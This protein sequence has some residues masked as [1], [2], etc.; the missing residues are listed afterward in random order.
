MITEELKIII[1]LPKAPLDPYSAEPDLKVLTLL[2][3]E[4]GVGLIDNS[5]APFSPKI[6]VLKGGGSWADS[7]TSD[8]RTLLSTSVDNV[9][10]TMNLKLVESTHTLMAGRIVELNRFLQLA[11]KF[12]ATYW[13]TQPVYLEWRGRGAPGSQFALIY[14]IDYA[15][16]PDSYPDESEP[17]SADVVLT[18]EREPAWRPLPPGA[19]PKLWAFYARGELPGAGVNKFTYAD[20]SLVNGARH[21]K[22]ATIQNMHEWTGT[23]VGAYQVPLSKNYVDIAAADVPGD[24]P[25]LLAVSVDPASVNPD[26]C[27]IARSIKP[28]SG[29]D[30]T[31]ATQYVAY[32]FNAGDADG[33]DA[34][35]VKTLSANGLI[36][37]GSNTNRYYA[38]T[39]IIASG[40]AFILWG[41]GSAQPINN[42]ELLRGKFVVLA[43]AHTTTAAAQIYAQLTCLYGSITVELPETTVPFNAGTTRPLWTYV[44]LFDF[45]VIERAIVSEFGTGRLIGSTNYINIILNYRNALASP[46]TIL[47][48]DLQFLPYDEYL[49]YGVTTATNGTPQVLFDGTGY[50]PR[51]QVKE[52]A[53]G[54]DESAVGAPFGGYPVELRGQVPKLEPNTDQRIYFSFAQGSSRTAYLE[55]IAVNLNIIPRWYGQRDV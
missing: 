41:T 53:Y 55:N 36:S 19:N 51:G 9:T 20:L 24:A 27:I 16:T 49:A 22:S 32:T 47:T 40:T 18:I 54:F 8:G 2:S 30:R 6:A 38:T 33:L 52:G 4:M 21:W 29:I 46:A 35:T 7:A 48:W 25:A 42:P 12:S 45:P 26:H 15:I 13:Q 14:S 31:G 34:T 5:E 10:E 3:N 28:A 11:R 39:S 23:G 1:G 17:P 44:G 43:R 50:F 37:N